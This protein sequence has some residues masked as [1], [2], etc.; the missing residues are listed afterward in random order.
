MRDSELRQSSI[1]IQHCPSLMILAVKACFTSCVG[2]FRARTTPLNSKQSFKVFPRLFH[3]GLEPLN[4]SLLLEIRE[5]FYFSQSFA[6]QP[7]GLFVILKPLRPSDG[8]ESHSQGSRGSENRYF[9][10]YPPD[11]GSPV[12]LA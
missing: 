1:S 8:P 5:V 12:F 4:C 11:F 3:G 2:V 10:Y 9:K 7:Q 6:T